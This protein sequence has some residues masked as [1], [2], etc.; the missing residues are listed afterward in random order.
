MDKLMNLLK[1][2]FPAVDFEQDVKLVTDGI[3]DS[4]D[5]VSL[6]SELEDNFDISISMEYITPENFDTVDKIW[7]MINELM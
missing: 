3:L 4:V 6:I 2:N 7:S 1:T 5:I